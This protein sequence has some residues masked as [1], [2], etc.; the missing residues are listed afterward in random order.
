MKYKSGY[1]W[2]LRPLV[3]KMSVNSKGELGRFS[4]LEFLFVYEN[5][6]IA[7]WASFSGLP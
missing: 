4:P 5:E 3:W 1:H 6:T 7:T 2:Q